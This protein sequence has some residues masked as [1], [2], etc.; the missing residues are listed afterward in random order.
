MAEVLNQHKACIFN[1]SHDSKSP[2]N[3]FRQQT[4][5]SQLTRDEILSILQ[6]LE[7]EGPI[8]DYMA[9]H[10]VISSSSACELM[11]SNCKNNQKIEKLLDLLDSEY[12]TPQRY[13]QNAKLV[14]LTNAL[15]SAGQHALASQL[16]RGRKIKP[17]PLASAKF[18]DTGCGSDIGRSCSVNSSGIHFRSVNSGVRLQL[19][20]K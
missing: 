13:S 6:N 5:H 11:Q 2:L 17:A 1:K 14:L 20:R 10:G 12:D 7:L 16:D 4:K 15:R 9:A 18:I 8:I 3:T 19:A